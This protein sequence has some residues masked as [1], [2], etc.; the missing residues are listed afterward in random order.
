LISEGKIYINGEQLPAAS[1]SNTVVDI[2]RGA[3]A[4]VSTRDNFNTHTLLT[5]SECQCRE[6]GQTLCNI[7]DGGLAFCKVC[8][9]GEA[10]LDAETCEQR[11][12]IPQEWVKNYVDK[13]IETAKLF[14]ENSVMRKA[15]L[16]RAAHILDMVEAFRESRC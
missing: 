2:I 10:E 3:F 4:S 7:C 1:V 13:I 14:D 12:R 8:K 6:R 15:C 16:E 11:Q 5:P 9:G